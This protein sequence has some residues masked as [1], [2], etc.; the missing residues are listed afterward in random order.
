[1]VNPRPGEVYWLEPSSQRGHEQEGRRPVLVVTDAR[2][3]SLGLT[4]IVPLTTTDRGWPLHVRLQV[5][6]RVSIA[7]CEQLRP[8]PLEQLGRL[9]GSVG[10][11]DLVEVR[12]MIRDI[13][14][15]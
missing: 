13:I 15:H 7:M 5:G 9:V 3:A 10:Y 14:G 8:I 1:M 6:D 11:D 2:L 4:W 12:S